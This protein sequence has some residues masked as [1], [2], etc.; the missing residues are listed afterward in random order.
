MH[1]LAVN[2]CE[3]VITALEPISQLFMIEAQ[4]M[5]NCGLQ[6]MYMNSVFGD[7]EPQFIGL[8][9]VESTFDSTAGHPH[10]ETV[11]VVVSSQDF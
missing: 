9:V 6:V 2:V 7:F 5:H 3:T 1:D 11:R 10:S 4:L 8:A